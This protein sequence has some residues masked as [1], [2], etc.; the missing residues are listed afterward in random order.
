MNAGFLL[1]PPWAKSLTRLSEGG[2]AQEAACTLRNLREVKI[3]Q[4]SFALC[5]ENLSF[6]KKCQLKSIFFIHLE[7]LL[8]KGTLQ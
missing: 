1:W 6:F 5:P 3:L 2:A 8:F 7:S 4:L